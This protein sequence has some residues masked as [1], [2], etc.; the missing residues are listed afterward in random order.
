[1]E[2]GIAHWEREPAELAEQV[3]RA[4]GDD[5]GVRGR[6]GRQTVKNRLHLDRP[7]VGWSHAGGC[8]RR[9]AGNPRVGSTKPGDKMGPELPL[10]RRCRT[11]REHR[12]ATVPG[13][14]MGP[15]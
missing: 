7:P 2:V 8:A 15:E 4:P 9:R 10:P 1:M 3:R 11:G 5:V 6:A 13:E 12:R 14:Y